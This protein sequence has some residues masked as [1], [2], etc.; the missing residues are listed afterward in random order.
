MIDMDAV[1]RDIETGRVELAASSKAILSLGTRRRIWRAMIDPQNDE[2]SYRHRIELDGM[3]VRRVQHL[4]NRV[5]PG[6]N[7]IEEMLALAQ[8]LVNQQINPK[9]A[10]SLIHI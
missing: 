9:Q 6:D 8:K 4:W 1:S 10:L 5:F 7:R 3:C 2:A